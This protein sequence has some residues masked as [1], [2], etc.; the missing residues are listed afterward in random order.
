MGKRLRKADLLEAIHIERS[1]LDDT[2]LQLSKRQMTQAGVTRGGWSVKDI[3]AHLA[4][5]QQMNL[6]WYAAGLRG[7]KPDLPAPGFSWRDLPRLNQTIYRKHR[8]RSLQT[9]VHEFHKNHDRIVA[10]ISTL[11]DS[12][13][14]TL[15]RYAWTGPSWTLSDFF[16]AN[17][18]AHYLWARKRIRSWLR[19]QTTA[20]KIIRN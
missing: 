14:V 2:I 20:G 11:Q 3:L 19:T 8:R 1:A 13:L 5:W 17:T 4:E 12:D 16:R 6:D 10:L 7:E 18:A 9:V 15:G